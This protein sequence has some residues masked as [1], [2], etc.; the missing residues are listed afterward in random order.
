MLFIFIIFKSRGYHEGLIKLFIGT[1]H[2]ILLT[3]L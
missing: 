2:V 3:K 1:E